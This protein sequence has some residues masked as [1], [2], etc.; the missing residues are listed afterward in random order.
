MQ[1]DILS[2]VC[3]SLVHTLCFIYDTRTDWVIGLGVACR[4]QGLYD[5]TNTAESFALA[6]KWITSCIHGH[7]RCNTGLGDPGW[8][9]TRLLDCG[10]SENPEKCRL[11]ETGT[12][13]IDGPYMTLSHCWGLTECLKFTTENRSQF[14]DNLPLSFLPKLYQE[15][16]YVTRKLGLRYLWIDSLCIIQRGDQSTDWHHE[17]TLMDRVYSNSYCNISPTNAPDSHHSMFHTRDPNPIY[18]QTVNIP[19][20]GAATPY[21]LLHRALWEN[22]VSNTR[23]NKR[24]W[25]LQERILSPRVLHF[26][27][28][29]IFWECR[30]MEACETY[31]DGLPV[32][33]FGYYDRLKDLTSSTYYSSPREAGYAL[34]SLSW[35]R[36]IIAYTACGLTFSKDKLVALSGVAKVMAGIFRDNYVAGMWRRHLERDLLWT[37]RNKR[38]DATQSSIYRAPSWSWAAVDGEVLPG[39]LNARSSNFLIEVLEVDLDYAADDTTGVLKGGWLRLRGVLKRLALHHTSPSDGHENW[40]MSVNG[41]LVSSPSDSTTGELQPH[42]SPDAPGKMFAEQVTAGRI[43]MAC[44]RG[45]GKAMMEASMLCCYS[46]RTRSKVLSAASVLLVDG[47]KRSR[48]RYSHVVQRRAGFHAKSTKVICILFA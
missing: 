30:Q 34:A 18:P 35:S 36:I 45:R 46:C 20:N 10:S 40:S 47:G 42:I 6:R 41:I 14:L 26:S 8:Y 31:P 15:A 39:A 44:L 11:I 7:E 13:V 22:E 38:V 24:G 43:C 23:L 48:R 25:V 5:S 3:I 28:S 17:V 29:Q 21:V 1:G 33:L 9:P 37:V 4:Q 19:V 12:T 16:V 27:R 2:V 32:S